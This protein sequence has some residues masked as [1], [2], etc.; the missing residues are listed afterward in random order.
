LTLIAIAETFD[1]PAGAGGVDAVASETLTVAVCDVE[2]LT[3]TTD[4]VPGSLTTIGLPEDAVAVPPF[5]VGA[6]QPEGRV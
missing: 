6:T 2:E 3:L 4:P 5:W 1:R